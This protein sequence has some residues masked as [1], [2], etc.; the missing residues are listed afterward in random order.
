MRKGGRGHFDLNEESKPE[1]SEKLALVWWE[2][3]E[4]QKRVLRPGT[5]GS[6]GSLFH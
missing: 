4:A 1:H 5:P 3:N 2:E 6:G